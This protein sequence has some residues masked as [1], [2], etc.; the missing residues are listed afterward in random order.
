M[1][2]GAGWQTSTKREANA[3]AAQVLGFDTKYV[4]KC[5]PERR[6]E[7]AYREAVKPVDIQ[8]PTKSVRENVKLNMIDPK[9]ST[10]LCFPVKLTAVAE[11]GN[12]ASAR[13]EL[14]ELFR[15]RI[16]V[17]MLETRLVEVLRFNK[18]QVYS[19]S[20][21]DDLSTSPPALGKARKGTL[22]VGFECDPAEADELVDVALG[23]LDK[24]RDG[25]TAFTVAN[26]EAALMQERREFEECFQKN[27]WWASTIQD[28]Y[29]SRCQAVT[30]DVGESM[31]LW[32]QVRSEVVSGFNTDTAWQTLLAVLPPS[33]PSAVVTMRPKRAKGGKAG[34][35]ATKQD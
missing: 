7:L 20:A 15:L 22:S 29:F 1:D 34:S 26:V 6:S 30:E 11:A 25:S 32:W 28:L 33:A 3:T 31:A 9:G 35:G 8:F 12:V 14:A 18:G 2:L 24:L 17:R 19:V 5:E 4:W 27:D 10:V 23:E 16:F 13:A 21:G